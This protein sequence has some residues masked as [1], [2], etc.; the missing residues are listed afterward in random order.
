MIEILTIRMGEEGAERA[1]VLVH[2]SIGEADFHGLHVS[3]Y[4]TNSDIYG[5]EGRIRTSART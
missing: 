4:F 1:V 2:R 5:G 3:S